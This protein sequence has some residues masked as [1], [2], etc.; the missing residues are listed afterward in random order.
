MGV[1]LELE[2]TEFPVLLVEFTVDGL[3]AAASRMRASTCASSWALQ[4]TRDAAAAA[5]LP[6]SPA[7][8]SANSLP[9][10]L[11]IAP[12]TPLAAPSSPAC[13]LPLAPHPPPVP[14]PHLTPSSIQ[15]NPII[16]SQGPHR[17]HS[18]RASMNA[19][20][21]AFSRC[22]IDITLDELKQASPQHHHG[23]Q[24]SQVRI[25]EKLKKMHTF[26]QAGIKV[27]HNFAN[28]SEDAVKSNQSEKSGGSHRI[29]C[30]RKLVLSSSGIYFR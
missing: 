6:A 4:R 30:C 5:A 21:I 20:Q 8:S 15:H 29:T 26:A 24:W 18:I 25:I 1:E 28:F 10:P 2:P 13:L 7:P 27:I 22:F 12:L 3:L 16:T 9:L 23:I 14:I 11:A 19:R 17:P